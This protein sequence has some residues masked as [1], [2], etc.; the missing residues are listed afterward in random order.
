MGSYS[1]LHVTFVQLNNHHHQKKIWVLGT[2]GKLNISFGLLF[3][4][5]PFIK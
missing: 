4:I 1:Y 5:E 2:E 3:S